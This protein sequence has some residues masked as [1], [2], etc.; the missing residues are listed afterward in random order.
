MKDLDKK[1]EILRLDKLTKDELLSEFGSAILDNDYYGKAD[2]LKRA[3]EWLI[4]KEGRIYK[5]ICAEDRYPTLKKKVSE[6]ELFEAYMLLADTWLAE[7]FS[8]IPLLTLAKLIFMEG[9]DTY[10]GC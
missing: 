2:F 7:E 1:N 4:E 3:K 6:N 8:G 10:C 9:L 5:A